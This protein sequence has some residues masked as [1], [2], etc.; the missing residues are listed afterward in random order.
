MNE[1][2][3]EIDKILKEMKEMFK[4]IPSAHKKYIGKHWTMDCE[5]CAADI[6]EVVKIAFSHGRN[7]EHNMTCRDRANC[8][9]CKGE[10]EL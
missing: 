3:K 1:Q 8:G 10:V 7:F 9:V 4:G 6:Y 2:D 5:G